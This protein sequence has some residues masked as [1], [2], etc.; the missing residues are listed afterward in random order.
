MDP[1]AGRP[2]LFLLAA[3]LCASVAWWWFRLRTRSSGWLTAPV[4]DTVTEE[5]LPSL[6]S[7]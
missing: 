1:D 3:L 5:P 6:P 7:A 2:S 4:T